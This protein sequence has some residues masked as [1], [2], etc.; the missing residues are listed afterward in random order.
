MKIYENSVIVWTDKE[1][2]IFN[3]IPKADKYFDKM[4]KY[5]PVWQRVQR[6]N[7]NNS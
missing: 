5:N 2:R 6:N 3:D 4:K 7:E 1:N